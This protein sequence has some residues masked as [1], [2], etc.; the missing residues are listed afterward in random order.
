MAKTNKIDEREICSICKCTTGISQRNTRRLPN[1]TLAE[2]HCINNKIL[3]EIII[4]IKKVASFTCLSLLN[5]PEQ[6]FQSVAAGIKHIP[7]GKI[8]EPLKSMEKISQDIFGRPLQS[9]LRYP[10]V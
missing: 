1:G 7:V 2:H 5:P 3:K 8:E 4:P 6:F 10:Q 9:F